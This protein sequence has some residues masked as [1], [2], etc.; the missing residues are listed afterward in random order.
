MVAFLASFTALASRLF[1]ASRPLWGSLPAWTQT[2]LP[3]LVPAVTALAQHSSATCEHGSPPHIIAMGREVLGGRIHCDPFTSE[4]FNEAVGASY[5][6][7]AEDS[8]LDP[9]RR[10]IFRGEPVFRTFYINPPSGL[11][12]EAWRFATARWLEGSAVFWV[13]F[14]LEQMLYL[15]KLGL[16]YL[17]FH[18]CI[19]PSRLNFVRVVEPSRQRAL[20]DVDDEDQPVALEAA[21][22]PTHGNFL[23]LMPSDLGQVERFN[24]EARA[25]GAEAF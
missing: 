1:D 15:Q 19:P 14:S 17:G 22:S 23:A 5:I 9:A 11:V 21:D 16:F 25:L 7:T 2:L 24:V 18:R 4:H 8:A 6:F 10:W 13:G 12:K 20:F 3:A